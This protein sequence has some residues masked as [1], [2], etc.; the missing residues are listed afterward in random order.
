MTTKFSKK[1]RKVS[2]FAVAFAIVGLFTIAFGIAHD[3]IINADWKNE[4]LKAYGNFGKG[5]WLAEARTNVTYDMLHTLGSILANNK[6]VNTAA[7]YKDFTIM[8]PLIKY[9]KGQEQ[10]LSHELAHHFFYT[11]MNATE[12]ESWCSTFNWT[13]WSYDDS[14]SEGFA[15]FFGTKVIRY[16][17][18]VEI[19]EYNLTDGIIKWG[20]KEWDFTK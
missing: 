17:P 19:E 15:E 16:A 6:D 10:S 5:I 3:F 20:K 18:L 7:Y 11:K 4:E 9:N 13:E 8:P 12:R 2:S 1:N 14:C